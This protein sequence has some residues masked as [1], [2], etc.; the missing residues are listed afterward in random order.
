MS[1][2]EDVQIEVA[3][4]ATDEVR[5]LIGELEDVLAVEY[6]PEQ[7][8]DFPRC[9]LST[10]GPVFPRETSRRGGGLR[11]RRPLP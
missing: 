4:A 8:H 10:A 9:D 3:L 1:N 7:R 11:R 6:P 2:S 5:L